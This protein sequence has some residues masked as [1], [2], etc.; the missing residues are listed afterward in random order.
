M[1]RAEITAEAGLFWFLD[2]VL[3]IIRRITD[4]GEQLVR[5][6]GETETGLMKAIKVALRPK[7]I[8]NHGKVI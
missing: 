6:R 8:M 7:N 2:Q 4:I 1:L 3:W 5:Y